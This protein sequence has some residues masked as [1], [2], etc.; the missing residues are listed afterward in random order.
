MWFLFYVRSATIDYLHEQKISYFYCKRDEEVRRER[1][2]ILLSLIKQ[3]ACLPD[4]S[5]IYTEVLQA[6]K[7]EQKDPSA[8]KKL[9]VPDCLK[10]LLSLLEYYKDAVIV[11]DAL[12]ECS[13]E[14]RGFILS[15]LLSI[16]NKCKRPVKAFISSRH[17]LEIE[18][19]LRHFPNVSIEAKD[20]AEDIENYV[21]STLAKKIEDKELLR[22]HVSIELR[23]KIEE[24]LQRDANGM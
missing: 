16:L 8:R 13:K 23:Q 15:D 11:L 18:D 17:N 5:G 3:L 12:D 1:H 6:Y 14:S 21:K 7:N 24:V 2:I 22:G 19:R 9:P 10:L 20:N 4:D